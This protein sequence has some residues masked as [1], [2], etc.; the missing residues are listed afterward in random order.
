MIF[1]K[2]SKQKFVEIGKCQN[3]HSKLI[4]HLLMEGMNFNKNLIFL[5]ITAQNNVINFTNSD[6]ALMAIDVNFITVKN[7]NI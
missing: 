4:V 1:N 5:K 2:N 3:V 6:I 7:L